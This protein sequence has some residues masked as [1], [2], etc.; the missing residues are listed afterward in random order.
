MTVG[1]A[2][3]HGGRSSGGVRAVHQRAPLTC[4][5]SSLWQKVS[6]GWDFPGSPVVKTAFQCSQCRFNPWL[7]ELK[8]HMTHGQKT[9]T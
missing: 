1:P 3:F 5:C 9:K 6:L 4:L 7:G 8:S 2:A